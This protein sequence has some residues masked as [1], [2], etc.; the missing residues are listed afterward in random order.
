MLKTCVVWQCT[1]CQF[2]FLWHFGGN[3]TRCVSPKDCKGQN[4]LVPSTI[5]DTGRREE[6][7]TSEWIA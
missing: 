6:V 2:E 1:E 7:D 5:V 3:P 4:I